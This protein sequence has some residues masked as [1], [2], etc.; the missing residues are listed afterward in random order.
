M[1]R[2]TRSGHVLSPDQRIDTYRGLPALTINPAWKY[3]EETRRGSIALGK[4][5]GFVLS[6]DPFETLV[7]ESWPCFR[8]LRFGARPPELV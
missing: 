1:A 6:A 5:A 4:L 3:C 7:M 2:T 8:S